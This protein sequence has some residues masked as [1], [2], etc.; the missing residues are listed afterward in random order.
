MAKKKKNQSTVPLEFQ[1]NC[2]IYTRISDPNKQ[3]EVS[4]AA[5]TR[6]CKEFANRFGLTVIDVLEDRGTGTNLDRP[7][8]LALQQRAKNQD[9][10]YILVWRYD[11]F[12]RSQQDSRFHTDSSA[13]F[14]KKQR[15][16]T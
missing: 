7:Q 15:E 5:Q 4:I 12:S 8:F 1:K 16:K 9:F 14:H 11:R 13:V 2:I 6:E 10:R 3:T